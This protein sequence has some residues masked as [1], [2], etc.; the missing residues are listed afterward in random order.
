MAVAACGGGGGGTEVSS[1]G[2]TPP[3]ISNLDASTYMIGYTIEGRNGRQTLLMG[4]GFAIGGNRI[5]TNSHVTQGILDQARQLA[6]SGISIVDVSAYQSETGA[7][8]PLLKA[9]IHPSYTGSTRSP[10]V[11]LFEARTTLPNTLTLEEANG[12]TGLRKGDALQL[13][14]FPGDLF[15]ALFNNFQPGLSIP[16]ATL[17]SGT[18]QAI[19]NFDTRVVVDPANISTVDMYQHSMDTSGGTSGSPILA[20]GRVVGVH[21]SGLS[22]T[23]SDIDGNQRVT[24]RIAQSTGS[25]GINVKHLHNLIAFYDQGVLEADKSFS[26]PPPAALLGTPGGQSPVS[27]GAGSTFGGSVANQNNFNVNHQ[28][29]FSV[30]NNLNV[31]GST[32]WPANPSLGLNARS[33]V[34][35]GKADTSGLIEFQDNT[36]ELI[37]G[38]RRGKYIGRLNPA[39]GVI[40][41]QYYELKEDTQELF[42]FGD[43]TASR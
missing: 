16:Q 11:G 39:N 20:N 31:S 5:A 25:W 37:S 35:T 1:G 15:D 13:N 41:G 18:M 38:F 43:W 33:F 29:Q 2:G 4:T 26:L 30:D 3:N 10:D 12:T 27:G 32:S 40:S 22:F 14:G 42:Y 34:L 36:P 24:R 17:F 6:Q 8:V 23:I 19:Q 7:V 28:V 9:A 21:N